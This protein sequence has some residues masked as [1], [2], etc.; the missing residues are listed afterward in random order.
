MDIYPSKVQDQGVI[1]KW[2]KRRKGH[3]EYQRLQYWGKMGGDYSLG[4][5][6]S[7]YPLPQSS[8]GSINHS[9]LNTS[10]HIDASIAANYL[11]NIKPGRSF[12]Q[13]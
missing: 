1:N 6:F 3:K 12:S 10:N 8:W 2:G 4:S 5:N 13:K 9:F 11:T 7:N